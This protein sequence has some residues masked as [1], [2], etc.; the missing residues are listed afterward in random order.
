MYRQLRYRNTDRRSESPASDA[1]AALSQAIWV[2]INEGAPL[3]PTCAADF[4]N[5]FE[6]G[7]KQF[8]KYRILKMLQPFG[9]ETCASTLTLIKVWV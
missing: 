4:G 8:A 2:K 9:K 3:H 5:A 6:R 7:L 1:P